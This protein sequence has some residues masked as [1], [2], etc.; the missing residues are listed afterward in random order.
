MSAPAPRMLIVSEN[1]IEGLP[2]G[3]HQ[4]GCAVAYSQHYG[5]KLL[6]KALWRLLESEES[7]ANVADRFFKWMSSDLPSVE[8]VYVFVSDATIESATSFISKLTQ[9]GKT[10]YLITSS[11]SDWSHKTTI[12][13]NLGI[14]ILESTARGEKKCAEIFRQHV[15]SDSLAPA[16]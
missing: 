1:R 15:S 11:Q 4:E 6:F 9:I 14:E 3:R 2:V 7:T 12:A 13:G 10:V 8:V 16:Q 5:F